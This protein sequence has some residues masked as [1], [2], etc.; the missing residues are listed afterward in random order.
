[1]FALI[2]DTKSQPRV[3]TDVGKWLS[4]RIKNPCDVVIRDCENGFTQLP[5][6]VQVGKSV[7]GMVESAG[8]STKDY[9]VVLHLR[10][11][12]FNGAVG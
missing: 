3:P 4:Y 8:E 5:E 2:Q 10:C 6:F 7:N 1:M 11:I 9:N 12:H